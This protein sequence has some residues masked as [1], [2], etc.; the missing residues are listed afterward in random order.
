MGVVGDTKAALKAF[1]DA[2]EQVTGKV[3]P[4]TEELAAAFEERLEQ[5]GLVLANVNEMVTHATGLIDGMD[6]VPEQTKA[7]LKAG[8]GIIDHFVR[9]GT[10]ASLTVQEGRAFI[11]EGRAYLADMKA[12]RIGLQT[13][14]KVVKT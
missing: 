8:L 3:I 9:V 11:A 2:A 6:G 4:V 7:L 1:T 10:Q 13:E 14:T 5:A 12:G